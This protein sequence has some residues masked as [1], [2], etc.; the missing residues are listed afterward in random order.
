MIE[1]TWS[2]LYIN[3]RGLIPDSIAVRD[4]FLNKHVIV[5]KNRTTTVAVVKNNVVFTDDLAL[6]LNRSVAELAAS[7]PWDR[8]KVWITEGKPFHKT[9]PESFICKDEQ[10]AGETMI[11]VLRGELV[12]VYEPGKEQPYK[13]PLSPREAG[14]YYSE[15]EKSFYFYEEV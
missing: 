2:E 15:V 5:I 10:M 13:S 7:R 6:N 14:L 1:L 3:T 9:M 4:Q 11:C 12:T 8:P